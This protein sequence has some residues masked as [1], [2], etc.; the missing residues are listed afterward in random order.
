MSDPI[1][2]AIVFLAT[3]SPARHRQ[4]A[5]NHVSTLRSSTFAAMQIA[6]PLEE[7]G[8]VWSWLAESTD[9]AARVYCTGR[10]SLTYESRMSEITKDTHATLHQLV[11]GEDTIKEEGRLEDLVLR[12][13]SLTS[14]QRPEY[15]ITIGQVEYLPK[16]L[17][18]WARDFG[19]I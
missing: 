1:R 11:A 15:F 9:V 18:R 12:Y 13:I 10:D 2:T 8:K 16:Q 14:S 7:C 4:A 19:L 5:E 17:E 6:P 3:C